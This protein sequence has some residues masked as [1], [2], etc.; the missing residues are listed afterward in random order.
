MS[1]PSLYFIALVL[2][3]PILGRVEKL[4]QIVAT[5]FGSKVCLKAPAHITLIPPFWHSEE[6]L[7]QTTLKSFHW[8]TPIELHLNGYGT[9]GKKVLF[10]KPEPNE[11]LILLQQSIV[12]H[13]QSAIGFENK[14]NKPYSFNPHVTIGNRDWNET[15]F[16]AAKAYF[17][18]NHPFEDSCLLTSISLL[19][20]TSGKWNRVEENML[21]L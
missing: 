9:F 8:H 14:K 3:E 6:K 2:P 19:K 1:S 18:Q 11:D 15:Q 4:K 13:F 7:L 5:E 12:N 20:L 17:T 16:T 21:K 10:I